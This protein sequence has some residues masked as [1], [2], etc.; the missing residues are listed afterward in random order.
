MHVLVVSGCSQQRKLFSCEEEEQTAQ[1]KL[2]AGKQEETPLACDSHT[3]SLFS[4]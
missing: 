2:Q 3:P 4:Q 1:G